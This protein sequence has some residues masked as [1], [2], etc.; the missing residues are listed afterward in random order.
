MSEVVDTA[1]ADASSLAESGFPALMIEN[2]G[3][4]PF[5]ADEAPPETVAAMTVAV[6][7]VRRAVGLPLGV[8][9]LR[10][11]VLS[12]LGI[13]AAT[14]ALFVRVNVLTGIM[15]TDQGPIIGRAAEVLRKRHDLAPDAE[16]WADV[17]VK[18][19]MPP[20]GIDARRAAGD[21]VERGLA[22][23]VIV[24]GSGTGTEPDLDHARDVRA[25]IPKETRLV[26]GSGASAENLSRFLDVANS[27]IVGSA[28]KVDG[29]ARNR[30][31]P[32]RAE[33]FI[34]VTRDNGLL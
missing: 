3:D 2:F 31:D 18:H 12:A 1:V 25:A 8:N 15:Y 17:M 19:A 29:D 23:A 4:V 26:I 30:V 21:T 27:V 14:G 16:I 32:L 11:D 24:S 33:Q 20:A 34:E 5:F 28:V 6:T 22:D 7:A 10:N 13:A 9:V